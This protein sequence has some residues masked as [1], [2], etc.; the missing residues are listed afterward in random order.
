[1]RERKSRSGKG[2]KVGE[3]VTNIQGRKGKEKGKKEQVNEGRMV[4][5]RR[6][7]RE[8]REGA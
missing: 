6:G 4:V 1:M 5:G 3:R 7:K 2:G 8:S